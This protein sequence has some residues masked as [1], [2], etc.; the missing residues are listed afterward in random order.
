M[1]W[2]IAGLPQM[3]PVELGAALTKPIAVHLDGPGGGDWTI[4]PANDDGQ[5]TV[6]EGRA[7]AGAP[8]A[9]VTSTASEFI[10]WATTPAVAGAPGRH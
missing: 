1:E 8:A 10:V 5:A 3:S 6:V 2:L 4:V 7:A 9:T